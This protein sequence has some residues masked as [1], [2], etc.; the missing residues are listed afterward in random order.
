MLVARAI[1][2]VDD[3]WLHGEVPPSALIGVGQCHAGNYER[4]YRRRLTA[5]RSDAGGRRRRWR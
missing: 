2:L 5:T 1:S 3:F 4:H